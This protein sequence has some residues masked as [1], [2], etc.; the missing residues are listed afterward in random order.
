MPERGVPEV[1]A[2]GD[3]FGEVLVQAQRP[4]DGARDLADLQRVGEA[5]AVVVALGRQEDLGL[6]LEAPERLA[7]DDAVAIAHETGA[8][9]VGPF[10]ALPA[11]AFRAASREG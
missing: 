3:G 7:V 1:V 2:E 11:A 5:R 4:R 10:L 6:V 8:N 9:G